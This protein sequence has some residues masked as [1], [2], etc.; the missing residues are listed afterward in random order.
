MPTLID[1]IVTEQ[2]HSLSHEQVYF[3]MCLQKKA[4]LLI[5]KQK[6]TKK[7]R[8]CCQCRKRGCHRLRLSIPS[9]SV[10]NE[11]LT[12]KNSLDYMP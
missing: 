1:K 8:M 11:P 12:K 4:L 2:N 6:T 5:H 9:F 10:L 3:F 7:H